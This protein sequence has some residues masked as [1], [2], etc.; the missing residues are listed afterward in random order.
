MTSGEATI[1]GLQLL[2]AIGCGAGIS[3]ALIAVEAE[4]VPALW[5]A[6]RIVGVGVVA[7]FVAQSRNDDHGDAANGRKPSP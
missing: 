2:G 6:G 5:A 4:D 7:L 1:L 3:A